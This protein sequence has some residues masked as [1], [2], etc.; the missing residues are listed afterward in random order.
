MDVG[1]VDALVVADAPAVDHATDH[2]RLRAGFDVELDVAV[3]DQDAV[4]GPQLPRHARV[5]DGHG[6]FVALDL[7]RGQGEGRALLQEGLAVLEVLDAD[8]GAARVQQDRQGHVLLLPNALEA[9]HRLLMVGM[10]AV[11]EVQPRHVHAA[12]DQFFQHFLAVAR[13]ADGAYNLGPTHPYP[14]S[15]SN[16]KSSSEYMIAAIFEGSV[17]AL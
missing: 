13:R 17:E 2:V 16:A 15:L 11:G 1:D 5:G 12:V 10:R 7:P 9:V 6:V 8:L 4:A 3:V 14:S